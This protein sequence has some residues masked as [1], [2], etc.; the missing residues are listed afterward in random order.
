MFY[1][2]LFLFVISL[3]MTV[4]CSYELVRSLG[5]YNGKDL[6]YFICYVWNLIMAV[7]W[8]CKIIA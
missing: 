6:F 5:S 3:F 8:L 2:C 7:C 4:V 1:I